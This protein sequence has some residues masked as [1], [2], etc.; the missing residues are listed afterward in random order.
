M[1]KEILN[2]R[3]RIKLQAAIL[4]CSEA[5]VHGHPFS[6]ISPENNG[7]RV[8]LSVKLQADCSQ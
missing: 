3:N 8:L 6:N 5:F 1:S 4:N 2:E 7:D